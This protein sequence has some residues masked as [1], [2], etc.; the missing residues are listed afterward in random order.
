MEHRH[1]REHLV[2]HL[3]DG[4]GG[5]HLRAQ[6]IEVQVGEQDALRDARRA[7]AVQHHGR[8]VLAARHADFL[9]RQALPLLQEFLPRQIAAVL[10]QRRDLAALGQLI[11]DLHQGFQAVLDAADDHRP[12]LRRVAADVGELLIEHVHCDRRDGLG[13]VQVEF[14]LALGGERMDHVRDRADHVDRVEH[15]DRHRHVRQTDRHALAGLDAA[16]LERCRGRM[17]VAG[18]RRIAGL[19]AE[20]FIGRKVGI[21]LRNALHRLNHRSF[22]ILEVAGDCAHLGVP[23]GLDSHVHSLYST[24]LSARSSSSS[25][26]CSR[27]LNSAMDLE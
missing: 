1:D 3:I 10:R 6:R 7:A 13:V 22:G 12:E 2:A 11:A 17:N 24:S 23:W 21:L 19:V 5:H 16:G 26:C 14:D 9:D 27:C 15:V 20:E 4:V 25:G 18:Q 8:L